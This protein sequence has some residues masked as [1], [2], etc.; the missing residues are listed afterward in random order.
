MISDL[1]FHALFAGFGVALIAGPLGCFVV[2]QR[3]AYH[4]H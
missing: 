4:K 1:L 2:W 3:M